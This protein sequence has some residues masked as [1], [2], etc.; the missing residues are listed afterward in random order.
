MINKRLFLIIYCL[1]QVLLLS[2]QCPERQPL[3]QRIIYLRDSSGS[4]PAAQKLKELLG[5]ESQLKKCGYPADS[6]HALLLQ[7]I[8]AAYYA[9][10][11]ILNAIKFTRQSINILHV[12][13]GKPLANN[14]Y[15]LKNYSNLITFYES[16]NDSHGQ[17]RQLTAALPLAKHFR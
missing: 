7:R 13:P 5:Y 14:R 9:V 4:V 1:L 17:R 8:G 10:G 15:L 12:S 2:G 3:Y 6:V 11:D 16:L